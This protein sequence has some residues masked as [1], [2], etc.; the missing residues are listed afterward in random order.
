MSF[1]EQKIFERINY[2]ENP[3][4]KGEYDHCSFVNCNFSGTDL[5]GINFTECE[6]N[7]CNLSLTKTIQTAIRNITF[8]DCKLMGIHFARCNEFLFAANFENCILDHSSFYKRNLKNT[9]FINCIL[10]EVDF[11]ECNLS[12]SIFDHCDLL[13]TTFDNTI[14]EKA[15]LISSYNYAINPETNRIKKAKFSIA[16]AIGLLRQYDIEI[17]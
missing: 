14:L 16:G 13:N 5:S 3:L 1:N 8:K 6:F 2:S 11:T 9:K 4:P 10:K 17:E 15:D 12:N 7:G